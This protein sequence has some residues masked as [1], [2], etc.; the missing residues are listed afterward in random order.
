MTKI[1]RRQK[2]EIARS[3]EADARKAAREKL[4]ELRTAIRAA[5]VGRREKLQEARGSCIANRVALR[6]KIRATREELRRLITEERARTRGTCATSRAEARAAGDARILDAVKAY[7]EERGFLA[8]LARWTTKSKGTGPRITISERRS[9]SD[10]EVRRNLDPALVPVW[11]AV[12]RE[13]KPGKRSSRTEAFL[14][15]A[16][17]HSADVAR[18]QAETFEAEAEREFRAMVAE[19]KRLSRQLGQKA[20]RVD[21]YED[22]IPF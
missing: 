21:P 6:E 1:V 22:A 10:D 7:A 18:I 17:D 8:E 2:K 20:S 16:H 9:E 15:W 4:R 19:E 14:Q 11:E 5:R 12:K 3:R 13:I